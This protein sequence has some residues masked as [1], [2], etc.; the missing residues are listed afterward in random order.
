MSLTSLLDRAVE[1]SRIQEHV[2]I[3][4]RPTTKISEERFTKF[5]QMSFKLML[6]K[7]MASQEV[8]EAKLKEKEDLRIKREQEL[9]AKQKEH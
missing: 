8:S 7:K 6:H 4:K 9:E 2:E 1:F 5:F 3:E